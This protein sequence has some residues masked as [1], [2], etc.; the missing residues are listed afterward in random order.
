MKMLPSYEFSGSSDIKK[1]RD[2]VNKT[3]RAIDD[4]VKAH[5]EVS[6]LLTEKE[7]RH[8]EGVATKGKFMTSAA[9]ILARVLFGSGGVPPPV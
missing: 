2:L 8:A 1:W 4:A 5:D 9:L 7:R 6:I 3:T